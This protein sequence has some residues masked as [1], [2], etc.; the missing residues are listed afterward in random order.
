MEFISENH[1]LER[2]LVWLAQTPVPSVSTKLCNGNACKVLMVRIALIPDYKLLVDEP[3]TPLGNLLGILHM[4][5]LE[6]K[7]KV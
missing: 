7:W 4:K 1:G 6:M 2:V 3:D 5:Y